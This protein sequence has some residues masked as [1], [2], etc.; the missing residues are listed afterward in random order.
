M[1]LNTLK[2]NAAWPVNIIRM[3]SRARLSLIRFFGLWQH[4]FELTELTYALSNELFKRTKISA[5]IGVLG[6]G[7]TVCTHLSIAPLDYSLTWAAIMIALFGAR[8]LNSLVS[9]E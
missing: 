8:I 5:A 4:G 7:I 1:I 9:T 6:V 2:I 3:P